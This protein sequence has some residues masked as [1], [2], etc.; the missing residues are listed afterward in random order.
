MEKHLDDVLGI[1]YREVQTHS[2][3]K[4]RNSNGN[5][6]KNSCSQWRDL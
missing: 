1:V 4:V 3:T 6:K 2:V 5:V